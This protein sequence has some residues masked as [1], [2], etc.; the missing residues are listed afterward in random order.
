MDR[1]GL[2]PPLLVHGPIDPAALLAA[3]AD[4]AAGGNV[5]F[6]GTTRGIT[7]GVVT[8]RLEY[9]AHAP[10]AATLLAELRDEAVLRFGLAGCAVQHRLGGVAVGEASVAIAASAPHRREAFAAAE[11]LIDRIK[12]EVPIWKC[13]ETPDGGRT[14][15]HPGATPGAAPERSASA[16]PAGNRDGGDA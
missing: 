7:D 12:R 4:A 3:V 5:L 11:W 10:M 13:E 1:P 14:W 2:P 16:H 6:L 8:S 9:D 15:I